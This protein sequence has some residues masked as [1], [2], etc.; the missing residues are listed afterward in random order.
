[1][2]VPA[3]MDKLLRAFGA[4]DGCCG[5]LFEDRT[6]EAAT[7]TS[8]EGETEQHEPPLLSTRYR[9]NQV[10]QRCSM[11]VL[12]DEQ[13]SWPIT[14]EV[15]VSSGQ[16]HRRF[17]CGWAAL[18]KGNGFGTGDK[19]AITIGTCV[20]GKDDERG[21]T[22]GRGRGVEIQVRRVVHDLPEE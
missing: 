1:M 20:D 11:H 2:H 12:D 22:G 15:L 13:R 5:V 16:R 8:S 10:V 19:L 9:K 14:Y 21:M 3:A 4:C 6:Q 17:T 7:T 18:C